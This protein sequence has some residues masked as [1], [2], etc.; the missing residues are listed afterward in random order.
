M[1]KDFGR[2][3]LEMDAGKLMENM[4]RK[5]FLGKERRERM[6]VDVKPKEFNLLSILIDSLKENDSKEKVELLR[7]L[8][9]IVKKKFESKRDNLLNITFTNNNMNEEVKAK[10]FG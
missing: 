9:F 2:L 3:P 5:E 7:K 1:L 4:K 8:F 10:V 6:S